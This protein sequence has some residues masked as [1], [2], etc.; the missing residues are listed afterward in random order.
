VRTARSAKNIQGQEAPIV[1]YCITTSTHADALHGMGFLCSLNRLHVAIPPA[2][3][4]RRTKSVR[5]VGLARLTR[6]HFEDWDI[7]LRCST[8]ITG[9]GFINRQPAEADM[10]GRFI[11]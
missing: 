1:I 10:L 3:E 8:L 4:L 7:C 2:K 11:Q 6:W 5:R 9:S